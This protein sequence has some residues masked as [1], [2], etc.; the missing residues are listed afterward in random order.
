MK[1]ALPAALIF[2]CAVLNCRAADDKPK[3]APG[4]GAAGVVTRIIA[5]TYG[6]PNLHLAGSD[7]KIVPYK[8]PDG[9]KWG[10]GSLNG[11]SNDPLASPDGKQLAFI[12]KG[13]LL[14]RPMEGG[15]ATAVVSGYLHEDLLITGWSPDAGSLVYYLGPSQ[16]DDAPPSKVKTE[17]HFVYD[18]KSKTSRG[19]KLDGALCGWLPD[20]T[21]LVHSAEKGTVSSLALTADAAPK[22]LIKDAKD[23]GQI[24]VHSDG[25]R[26]AASWNKFGSPGS[27]QLIAVDLADGKVTPLT[28][29]GGWAD[30][31]W[32]RWSPSGKRTSWLARTGMKEDLPQ[33]VLVVD[34]KEITKP[35]NL[36][37]YHWLT[38]NTLVVVEA[39]ALA[40][41]DAN[42]GK[43]L[44]RKKTAKKSK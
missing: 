24:V 1:F 30:F 26:I 23:Y 11:G 35:A 7:G 4:E 40:V 33:S 6:A 43:E 21:M 25:R 19:I 27:S 22:V 39:E 34:G 12:Q 8:M 36:Q 42:T 15:K 37:D 32:P 31:E 3:A 28:K 29:P 18:L 17:K 13:S 20:G 14:I 44:G 10:N 41:I 16:A 5:T 38:E 9:T 2:S